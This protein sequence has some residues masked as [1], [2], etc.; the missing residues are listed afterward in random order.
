MY[1]QCSS[2]L[3]T[4]GRQGTD[5]TRRVTPVTEH[6]PTDAQ[7]ASFAAALA[8]TIHTKR[9]SFKEVAEHVGWT[10]DYVNKL[11]RGQRIPNPWAMFEVERFL[12]CPPGE[13][14]RHLGYVPTGAP[15]SVVASIEADSTL[16]DDARRMLVA[17]YR[18]GRIR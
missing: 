16:T 8:D 1:L 12:G 6:G 3:I 9:R 17:T 7:L 2:T 18:A 13:L 5:G 15:T 14:T 4:A 10:A 11:T